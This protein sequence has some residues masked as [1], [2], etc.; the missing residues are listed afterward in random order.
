MIIKAFTADELKILHGIVECEAKR[1]EDVITTPLPTFQLLRETIGRAFR[2]VD[3]LSNQ[4]KLSK[5]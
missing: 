5:Q 1:V 3:G 2:Y 4:D